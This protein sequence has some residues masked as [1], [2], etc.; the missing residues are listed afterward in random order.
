MPSVYVDALAF[1]LLVSCAPHAAGPAL[2]ANPTA[3]TQSVWWAPVLELESLR[4]IPLRLERPFADAFDVVAQAGGQLRNDVARNCSTALVLVDKGYQPM[5]AV[6]AA[7][8]KRAVARC[9]VIKALGAA[10]PATEGLAAFRLDAHAL[11]ALPPTLGPQPNPTDIQEREA[12]TR[13]GQSWR[14]HNPEARVEA[15]NTWQARATGADWTTELE[16]LARADFDAD[17][18]EDILILTLSYGTEGS[19]TEV[20]LHQL[21]RKD[22]RQLL[23]VVRQIPI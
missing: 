21:T 23:Q 19:W 15:T 6:D 18:R 20:R 13:A 2:P 10:R 5:S 17:G 14:E 9:Q 12:A 4:S 11:S 22:G 1:T 3:P 16:L 7:A 8:F